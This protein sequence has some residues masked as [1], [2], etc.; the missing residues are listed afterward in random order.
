MSS[1][2]PQTICVALG[3]LGLHDMFKVG[4]AWAS[5]TQKHRGCF[6]CKIVDSVALDF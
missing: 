4:E 1:V 6:D 2:A 5:L 3:K